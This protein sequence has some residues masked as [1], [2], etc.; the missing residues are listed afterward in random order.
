M[1]NRLKK[2]LANRRRVKF[3][4]KQFKSIQQQC[5]DA[6]KLIKVKKSTSREDQ[7]KIEDMHAKSGKFGGNNETLA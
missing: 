5:I 3:S 1:F 7:K 4:N 6:S 2:I